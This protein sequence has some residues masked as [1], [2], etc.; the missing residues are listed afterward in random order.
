MRRTL[1]MLAAVVFLPA[2]AS[3]EGELSVMLGY[4]GGDASFLVEADVPFIACLIPPCVVAEARTPESETLGLVLD[5]PIAS[6][7]M[8]EVLLNR[9]EDNLRLATDLSAEAGRPMPESFDLT[10]LQVGAQ[11]RWGTDRLAP[12]VAGGIGVARVETSAGILGSPVRAGDVGRTLGAKE[13]LSVSLGGGT[14]LAFGPRWGL[15]L[16]ARGYLTDLP[17][18][19]G[20]ELVQTEVSIGLSAR[21]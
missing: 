7:W 9:Q 20:G 21:L 18:E 1:I 11:H 16:E 12:F 3:A 6:G 14:R 19:M 4:R 8:F 17:A 5:V 10:T 2:V 13:V 15:R